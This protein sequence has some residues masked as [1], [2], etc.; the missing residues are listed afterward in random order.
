MKVVRPIVAALVLALAAACS[1]SPT[2][3]DTRA[4]LGKIGTGQSVAPSFGK[5]G[6]GQ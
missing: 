3:P 1:S 4:D 2:A 6:T 5:L